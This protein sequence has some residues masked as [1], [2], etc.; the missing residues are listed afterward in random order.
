M[1]KKK[2]KENRKTKKQK[3]KKTNGGNDSILTRTLRRF[4]PTNKQTTI[5]TLRQFMPTNKQ[6]KVTMRDDKLSKFYTRWD[7]ISNEAN[8]LIEGAKRRNP[9][10]TIK[11]KT[12]ADI[13]QLCE[14]YTDDTTGAARQAAFNLSLPDSVAVSTYTTNPE[15][16]KKLKTYRNELYSMMNMSMKKICND[17]YVKI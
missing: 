7:E 5:R 11:F 13:R 12:I 10:I 8:N 4:M 6:T 3:N 14:K 17:P 1:I 2:I 16:N 15:I 9:R